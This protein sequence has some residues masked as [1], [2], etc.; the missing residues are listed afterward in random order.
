MTAIFIKTIQQESVTNKV[1]VELKQNYLDFQHSE[2]DI[3]IAEAQKQTE[4]LGKEKGEYDKKL[5][6]A[7]EYRNHVLE[8][9]ERAGEKTFSLKN[10]IEK[11]SQISQDV[12]FKQ[13]AIEDRVKYAK[14][15]NAKLFKYKATIKELEENIQILSN[16]PDPQLNQEL[17]LKNEELNSRY[18]LKTDA[19]KNSRARK[20]QV[21]NIKKLI[22]Q[23]FREIQETHLRLYAAVEKFNIKKNLLKNKDDTFQETFSTLQDVESRKISQLSQL[24]EELTDLLKNYEGVAKEIKEMKSRVSENDIKFQ[25]FKEEVEKVQKNIEEESLKRKAAIKT[26]VEQLKLIKQ[27]LQERLKENDNY[28]KAI[29][30]TS[31]LLHKNKDKKV[32]LLRKLFEKKTKLTGE[33]DKISEQQQKTAVV[34]QKRIELKSQLEEHHKV[35][36]SLA[37]RLEEIIM[38]EEKLSLEFEVKRVKIEQASTMKIKE[39]REQIEYQNAL[40]EFQQVRLNE[41][42]VKIQDYEKQIEESEYELRGHKLQWKSAKKRFERIKKLTQKPRTVET[43]SSGERMLEQDV[44]MQITT[45]AMQTNVEETEIEE[46][47]QGILKSQL[48]A[49]FQQQ[50]TPKRVTF[51]GIPSTDSSLEGSKSIEDASKSPH[52]V[53]D[54]LITDWRSVKLINGVKKRNFD[55]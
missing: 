36:E 38:Q 52:D 5:Y 40:I 53:L 30:E 26:E 8:S 47:N 15:Q 49:K 42:M 6:Y 7:T 55:F 29:I 48:S 24:S 12:K 51:H 34:T 18:Q 16:S 13:E 3:Q 1:N 43:N 27:R 17:T 9:F 33:Q 2:Q 28:V 25:A 39:L 41:K 35:N 23:T 21:N 14:A 22:F 31:N 10:E 37:K 54:V 32:E 19:L 44:D 4:I 50:T 46:K 45:I 11:I 20:I